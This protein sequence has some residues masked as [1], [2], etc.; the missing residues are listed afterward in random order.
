MKLDEVEDNELLESLED[1]MTRVIEIYSSQ[2]DTPI[3]TKKPQSPEMVKDKSRKR[4]SQ[5][6]T[7]QMN[8]QRSGNQAVKHASAMKVADCPLV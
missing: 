6:N 3:V 8:H 5:V 7:K 4:K 2:G 1:S